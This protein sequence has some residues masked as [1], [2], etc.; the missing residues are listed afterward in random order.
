MIEKQTTNEE[1]RLGLFFAM[2]SESGVSDPVLFLR[3]LR[4]NRT[5]WCGPEE[6]DL[7]HSIDSF[8]EAVR[9]TNGGQT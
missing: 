4:A 9:P 5:T 1:L 2:L 3:Q 8:L 7:R 6:N